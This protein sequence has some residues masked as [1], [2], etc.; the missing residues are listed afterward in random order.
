[1]FTSLLTACGDGGSGIFSSDATWW[2]CPRSIFSSV[3]IIAT[4][5]CGLRDYVCWYFMIG[6]IC[7]ILLVTSSL[8]LFANVNSMFNKGVEYCGSV[9]VV[10]VCN[11]FR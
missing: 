10:V 1:M 4:I 2:F 6:A 7:L 3:G 11:S 8:L 9:L 5:C